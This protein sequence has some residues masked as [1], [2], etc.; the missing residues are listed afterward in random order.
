MITMSSEA[1]RQALVVKDRSPGDT[2]VAGTA[3]AELAPVAAGA[4]RTFFDADEAAEPCST[5][6]A[7]SALAAVIR[8]GC[9]TR[10]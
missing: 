7:L 10:R 6:A 4:R 3:R 9:R 8:E 1:Q 2:V 5:I